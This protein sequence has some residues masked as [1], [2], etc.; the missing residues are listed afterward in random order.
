MVSAQANFA[1][2]MRLTA[3]IAA[4][5]F[6]ASVLMILWGAPLLPSSA[7]LPVLGYPFWC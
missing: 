3:F 2:W 4:A 1:L 5:L 6:A 7:P